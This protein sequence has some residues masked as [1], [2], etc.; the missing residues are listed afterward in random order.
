[1]K[2]NQISVQWIRNKLLS[3]AK[4]ESV[5]LCIVF[6]SYGFLSTSV[7]TWY[8]E[9]IGAFNRFVV[10]PWGGALCL[11][12]L[13]RAHERKLE[14][15]ADI[16]FLVLLYVWIVIPF[17]IRF[18]F[19]AMNVND[20]FH[21]MVAFF[22]MYA[23]TVEETTVQRGMLMDVAGALFAVISFVMGTLLLYC[24]YTAQTFGQDLSEM[25]FGLYTW[26]EPETK[27]YVLTAGLHYNTTGMFCVCCTLMCL[28]GVCRRKHFISKMVHF[29]PALMMAVVVVLTQS[30]TA[31]YSMLA[32]WAVGVYGVVVGNVRISRKVLRQLAAITAG[33]SVFVVGY[34]G[35]AYITDSAARHYEA[36]LSGQVSPTILSAASAEEIEQE[37]PQEEETRELRGRGAGDMTFTNRTI[38]WKNVIEIWKSQ[39]KH[40]VIGFGVGH[41]GSLLAPWGVGLTTHN[42]YLGFITNYGLIG[43]ALLCCFFGSIVVPMCRAFFDSTGRIEAG[44]RVMAM[45]IVAALLTGMM[46]SEPLGAMLPM[47]AVLMF[48]LAML[49][50]EG[51]RLKTS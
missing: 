2:F 51:R 37:E 42:A 49:T 24:A 35:A 44:S 6:F 38:I 47:N 11:F 5:F 7:L 46:E 8:S 28:L 48:S 43:F 22:G 23:L 17:G 30:R 32:A 21:F 9:Q 33:V 1:M 39:P 26:N 40:A 29:V 15:H 3:V 13:Y 27:I 10:L 36:V 18:G 12:R 41:I 50:A 4:N 16:G 14:I 25:A 31:R 20:W 45:V 19:T 34:I